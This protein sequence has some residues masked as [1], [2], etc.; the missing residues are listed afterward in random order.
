MHSITNMLSLSLKY[1]SNMFNIHATLFYY[2]YNI[3]YESNHS[4]VKYVQFF[5]KNASE[6]VAI[7]AS[8]LVLQLIW[9][10]NLRLKADRLKRLRGDCAN[11][12]FFFCMGIT[13][14]KTQ[15]EWT[16]QAQFQY[17]DMCE[18]ANSQLL[19]QLSIGPW[20]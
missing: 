12:Y 9:E 19:V 2:V 10:E 16:L 13:R 1:V 6:I 18:T 20:K 3:T 8:L 15:G 14:E 11:Q 5:S 4:L 17:M 7:H